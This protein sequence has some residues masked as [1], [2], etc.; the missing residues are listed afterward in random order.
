MWPLA[1]KSEV[2]GLDIGFETLKLVQL[3]I[4]GSSHY[5]HGACNFILSDRILEKDHFKDKATTAKIIIEA[6]RRAQPNPIRARQIVSTLPET[7]VFSKTIQIPKRE[8]GDYNSAIA[9]EV[10]QFLPVSVDEV[11]LD[12]QV[13]IVHPNESL[14]DILVVAAPNKLVDDYAEMARMANLELA[15]LETKPLA[16]GR[17]LIPAN[18][19]DCFLVAQI[20]T[21]ITRISIWDMGSIRLITTVSVGKN[22]LQE[23]PA[24][25][26]A[27]P[28]ENKADSGATETAISA[29]T[30]APIVEEA[31]NAIKYHQNRDYQPKPVS[32]IILCGSGACLAKID[33]I[34]TEQIGINC[35]VV[36]PKLAGKHH[37]NTDFST[38]YGLAL[39]R[40]D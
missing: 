13:L 14:V 28:T 17:A 7:F 22:Q 33:Q 16:V 27:L 6:C 30:V 19:K 18:S 11:Y 3:D 26:E 38:A 24:K 37:L 39:W 5:L 12:Y 35:E 34:M 25:S 29:K 4:A 31:L 8:N 40:S 15:A 1:N 9:A 36:V 20:G 2:F 10:A 23:T 21:E 32:K